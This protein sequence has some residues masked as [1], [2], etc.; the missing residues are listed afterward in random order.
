MEINPDGKIYQS[1]KHIKLLQNSKKTNEDE[2][3]SYMQASVNIIFIHMSTK[4][5]ISIFGYT[6]VAAMVK[7]FKHPEQGAM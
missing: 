1:I 6:S 7:D 3:N 5:G 4:K 2:I